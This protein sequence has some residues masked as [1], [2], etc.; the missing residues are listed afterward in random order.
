MKKLSLFSLITL[1]LLSGCSDHHEK[2][3]KSV[4]VEQKPTPEPIAIT[5]Y[6]KQTELFVEFNPFVLNQPST[7]LAHLTY[8]DTFKPFKQGHVEACLTFSNQKKECFS[9]D[10][11][12]FEGIFKPIAVPSQSGLAELDIRIEQGKII[13]THKLGKFQVY[14]SYEQI[15]MSNEEK[16]DDGISYLKEQQWKVEFATQIATKKL[17]RE[18][19]PTFAKIEVPS[20]QEYILSAPVAGIVTPLSGLGVGSQ[21]NKNME[22]VYITPLLGQK[23]DISTLQ[24]ELKQAEVNLALKKDENERV[25]ILKAKNAVSQKRII[26]AQQD[27]EMAKAKHINIVQ[28]FNQLDTSRSSQTGISLKSPI[29]GKIA[30]QLVLPGSYMKEGEPIIHIVNPKKLWINVNIPQSD[31]N[32]VTKPLGV[33]LTLNDSSL[34]FDTEKDTKFLYFNDTVDSKTRCASL[35]FEID[36]PPSSLKA[37]AGHAVKVYSG[38]TVR[39]LAIPKSSIVN[40]NGQYV[41]YVQ[42]GGESFERRNIQTGMSTGDY[43]EVISGVSEGE[44]VVF[45]GAYQVLLSAVS[46]AAAGSGHAH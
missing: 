15:P 20:N 11:P 34:S 14:T 16:A 17:L 22:L 6:T 46:P 26:D 32:K 45:K 7:F 2:Y 29:E 27:Y 25:Q 21:V 13:E 43:I 35:L 23:E 36:N 24:F 10:A 18:S 41:V 3:E 42:V 8:M 5:D 28:R 40:D 30:K 37:G 9:V 38:K 39:A 44:H 31:I 4:Q 1:I 19:I 12:A 33:E